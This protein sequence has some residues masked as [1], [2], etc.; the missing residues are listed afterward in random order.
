M[1]WCK[2]HHRLAQ[3]WL[4]THGIEHGSLESLG[5]L[6]VI[7]K[8]LS[9]EFHFP[10]VDFPVLCLVSEVSIMDFRSDGFPLMPRQ[11]NQEALLARCFQKP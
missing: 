5:M 6:L 3:L 9:I 8:I 11:A 2:T 1:S 7:Q 10:H 4:H